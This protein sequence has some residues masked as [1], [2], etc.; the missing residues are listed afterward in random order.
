MVSIVVSSVV[1]SNSHSAMAEM[2][3]SSVGEQ[4]V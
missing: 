2:F 4:V 3:S 1:F